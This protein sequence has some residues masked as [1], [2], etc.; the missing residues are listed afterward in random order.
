M[1]L[2][3]A[4]CPS[5]ISP[6]TSHSRE[7]PRYSR[8]EGA[9]R[10]SLNAPPPCPGVAAG[11]LTPESL[12]RPVPS[13]SG[14]GLSFGRTNPERQAHRPLLV[15]RRR[16]LGRL[17]T[18]GLAF[19]AEAEACSWPH[20]ERWQSRSERPS[21]PPWRRRDCRAPRHGECLAA[22]EWPL[23]PEESLSKAAAL[24]EGNT[25]SIGTKWKKLVLAVGAVLLLVAGVGCSASPE[26]E[27]PE[28][29]G[30]EDAA[31]AEETTTPV[32]ARAGLRRRC[33]APLRGPPLPR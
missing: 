21:R 2:N 26:E 30:V 28:P 27:L 29:V 25:L 33:V 10:G 20:S 22:W 5:W 18:D 4:P 6:R 14:W 23:V 31:A 1:I 13:Q 24:G 19:P 16:R 8:C 32:T 11:P 12:R 3:L 15:Q 9:G 7:P 17:L